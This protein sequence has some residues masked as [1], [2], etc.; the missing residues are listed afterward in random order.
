[1]AR[2]GQARIRKF[3]PDPIYGE[4]LVT[5]LIGRAMKDGKKTV[6]QKQ[7]YGAFEIIKTKTKEDPMKVSI[8]LWKT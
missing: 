2:R 8:L 1:M 7:I 4:V 5:K 3:E 6:A